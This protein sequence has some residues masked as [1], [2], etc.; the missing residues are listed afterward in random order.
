LE[1]AVRSRGPLTVLIDAGHVVADLY[2]ALV[3][4]EVFVIDRE[5][6]LRYRGAMDDVNFRQQTATRLYLEEAVE[7][8]LAEQLPPMADFPAFGCSIVRES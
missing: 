2:A 7:S 1:E 6:V 3:T 5:G 8:L 4:P